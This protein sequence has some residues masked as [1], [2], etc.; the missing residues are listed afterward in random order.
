LKALADKIHSNPY[1]GINIDNLPFFIPILT[2]A[3]GR[4]LVHDWV[5]ENRAVYYLD[6]Q[7][8]GAKITLL[9]PHRI[10]VE[11]P[12]PLIGRDITA[13][14]AIRPAM[15]LFVGM[16]AAAKGQSVLRNIYNIERGYEGL[17]EKLKKIGADVK[18]EE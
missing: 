11:G 17:M 9:D 5:Y 14:D 6:F 4:T 16:L 3:K 13:P 8:L 15:T 12:T 2:Q 10:F 18:R 1:P 7:K